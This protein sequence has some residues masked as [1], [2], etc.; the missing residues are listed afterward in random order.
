[1]LVQSTAEIRMNMKQTIKE[2]ICFK[3]VLIILDDLW[4]PFWWPI[5]P[6]IWNYRAWLA[7]GYRVLLIERP[8]WRYPNKWW[9]L[10]HTLSAKERRCPSDFGRVNHTLDSSNCRH[11][12]YGSLFFNCTFVC[13]HFSPNLYVYIYIKFLLYILY[14]SSARKTT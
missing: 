7:L 8:W 4:R 14:W 13:L 12:F 9:T 1:M 3:S 6:M 11:H 2:R 5:D 10:K